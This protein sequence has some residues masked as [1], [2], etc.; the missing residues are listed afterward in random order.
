VARIDTVERAALIL[1]FIVIGNVI[2]R[3]FTHPQ[4]RTFTSNEGAFSI[5]MPA[6]PKAESQSFTLNGVT[7]EAH[8]FSAFSRTNAQFTIT[9][10]DASVLPRAESA[11]RILDF[12]RRAV[13]E[14]DE[15]RLIS[16]ENL[17]VNGYPARYY[18]ATTEGGFQ[19]DEKVILVG[20][21]LHILLV[22]HG[23]DQDEEDVKEFFESFRFDPEKLNR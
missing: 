13:T 4:W 6:K 20:R 7:A 10:A 21:R 1:A 11:E 9:Y 18:K 12:Q 3:Q 17:L 5:L 14:G 19:A 15:T 2:V 23:R 22:V 8:S 16:S